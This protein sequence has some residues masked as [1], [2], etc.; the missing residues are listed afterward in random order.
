MRGVIF[1]LDGTLV[2]SRLDFARIRADLGLPVGAPILETLDALA[3][4]EERERLHARLLRHELDCAAAATLMPGARALLDGL[5]AAGLKLGI[6]TR[7]AREVTTFTLARLALSVDHVVAREDAPPKPDPTGLH[8]LC[9]RWGLG[10]AE[11]LYVGDYLFDLQAGQNA[12]I[13]TLLYAPEPPDFPCAGAVIIRSLDDVK[14][15][16]GV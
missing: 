11:V 1:D 6:F 14:S 4:P 13:K 12:G 10:P 2:D 16:L 8:D 7:N 3:D 5:R 15:V 9:A